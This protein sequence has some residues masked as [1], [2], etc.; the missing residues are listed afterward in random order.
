[1]KAVKIGELKNNLSKYLRMVRKG[2][3]IRVLDRDE[4][5]AELGPTKPTVEEVFARLVREGRCKPPTAD[6][7]EVWKEIRSKPLR[8]K[9]PITMEDILDDLRAIHGD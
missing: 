6:A 8:L 3:T 7:H 2:E 5:I 4:P 1:M 9:K